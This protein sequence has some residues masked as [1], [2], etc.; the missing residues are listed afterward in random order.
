[1]PEPSGF[2]ALKAKLLLAL[3]ITGEDQT[4]GKRFRPEGYRLETLVSHLCCF[5][6]TVL[7]LGSALTFAFRSLFFLFFFA[8]RQQGP[9][10]REGTELPAVQ[11]LAEQ[12]HGGRLEGPYAV[13]GAPKG[14]CPFAFAG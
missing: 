3:K 6:P 10:K 4:P 8:R 11:A 12:I 9:A 7:E 5:Q 14:R 13:G 2:G 1:M